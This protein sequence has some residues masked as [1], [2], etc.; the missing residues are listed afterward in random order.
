MLHTICSNTILDVSA[1]GSMFLGNILV[2]IKLNKACVVFTLERQRKSMKSGS[3]FEALVK[4]L[5]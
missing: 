4:Y 2:G 5:K 3:C 1:D